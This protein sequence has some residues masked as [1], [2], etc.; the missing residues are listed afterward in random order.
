MHRLG[1]EQ[2]VELGHQLG[3]D[4]HAVLPAEAEGGA[5]AVLAVHHQVGL[6]G[7]GVAREQIAGDVKILIRDLAAKQ[8]L[9]SLR[10]SSSS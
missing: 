2:R 8:L 4:R 7:A 9:I 5:L 6:G 1:P 10:D 3:A